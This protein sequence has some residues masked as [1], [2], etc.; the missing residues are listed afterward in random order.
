MLASSA[1]ASPADEISVAVHVSGA[2]NAAQATAPQ[3]IRAFGTVAMRISPR[4]LPSYVGAAIALR[5]DLSGK[6]VAAALSV[7]ARKSASSRLMLCALA[8]RIVQ[9]AIAANPAGA[10]EIAK[11]AAQSSP[12]LRDCII[13]AAIA[14]APDLKLALVDAITV[15]EIL[16][17]SSFHAMSADTGFFGDI[18]SINPANMSERHRHVNSPEHGQGND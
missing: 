11:V 13:A 14:A 2:A 9:A 3:F 4:D 8:D 15:S 6:I 18:G 10:V 12:S 7:A 1:S 16:G 5:P 17:A